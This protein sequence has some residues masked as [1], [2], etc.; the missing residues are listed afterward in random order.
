MTSFTEAPGPLTPQA[1]KGKG[2][3]KRSP[4][5]VVSRVMPDWESPGRRGDNLQTTHRISKNFLKV[6]VSPEDPD[7]DIIAVHGLNPTNTEFHAEATWT[8]EDKLWLRDFL[9]PQLPSARV[10]LFGYNANVAFE[11]SKAGV[12]EQAIN[13]L[14]RIASKREEAEERPIVFVA[15]SL[16]GIVVK[17]A[18]VEAKLDDSYKSIREATYG[19]AFFGT[20][21]QGGNFL[22]LGDI[23]ASIIRGVLRNPSSTFME[24]LKKDSLFS[25]TLVG[26]FRHQLEDHHVLSFF[27]TLPMGRLGLIV[28]QKSATLG[29]AGLRERQ[30]PMD[31]D[32][33]GVCKF[34]SAEGDDYEQVSFN[35]VRLVKSA[36]KAAAERAR[37][38]SLSV[39]SSR[40]LSEA[41]SVDTVTKSLLSHL[42]Y[43]VD[44]PFN[45]YSRQHDPTCLPDTRVDL[46]REIYT[47]AD[48][49]D[50]RF[51]YWLNGLAGTGKS[52]IART[53][54]RKY[55]E[56]G[57]L[58]ASFFFLR[59]GGDVGHA[60]KFFITIAVQLARK[61]QSLQRYI[62]DAVRKNA[63]IATQS[64]GDQWRQVVLGP[65]SKLGGD[66]YPSSYILVIDALDECDNDEDIL[67]I[68]KLLAEAQTLRTVRLRV[69]LTSRSEIPIRY[70]FYQ[71]P[72]TEHQDFVLHHI[73]PSI[74]DHDITI[75]LKY[76]LGLIAQKKPSLSASWPG[77]ETVKQ[78]VQ[79]ASGLFIWA[80][81]ACRFIQEVE[82][83]FLIPK[84]LATILQIGSSIVGEQPEKYLNEIYSTV[85][86]HSIPAKGS[87]EE[88]ERFLSMLRDI[89][90]SIV[91]LLS[92][93]S[94]HSLSRLLNFQP[95]EVDDCLEDLHAI[96]DISRDHTRLLRLHH[97]SFRDFLLKK[98]RCNDSNFWVD[99]KPANETLAA[100]CIQ[101]M[102]TSL[103][104]D[105]CGVTIPGT[106]VADIQ[107]SRVEQCLPLEVQYAC[108]HWVKHLRRSDAQLRD[109]D[110]V[111]QFLQKHLL[112]WLEALGWMQKISEG[113]LEIISLESI[114]SVVNC[115]SLYGF[116]HDLKRFAL[117]NRVGIEQAPLQVY[118]SALFF[119][120]VMSIVR[121]QFSNKMPW[122]IK[123][124]PEVE[125]N[126]S[127]TLQTL[128]GHSS[129]VMA[130]AFSPDGKQLASGSGDETVRI[131]DAATGATLQTFEGHSD[132]VGAVAFSPDGKQLASG[133]GDETVRI[134]DAPTG[135]TLQ[136]LEGHSGLVFGVAFSPDG[137]QLASGSGDET[138]R[139]WD[140]ATGATLQTLEGH[141]GRVGAVAF[142]PDG[143]QLASGSDDETVRIW[144]AATGAT[145]QTL[146]GHSD[147]VGAVAFSPDGK[148]LASGSGD[149]TVRIW[150]AGTGATL[151]T[152]EGHSGL[153]FAVAFSPD[154]KQ[155]A[156]GSY[157]MTVRIWDAATGATLQTLE[158]HSGPVFAVAFSPD[159]KQLAS[160]SGD[161]TVRIWDAATGATLQ[162]LE[163]HSGPVFGV[164][165]SPDGKQLAS[166]SGD[167]TVRIRDAATG[168]TLQTF[169]ASTVITRLS[170]SNDGS[171]VTNC[172]RLDAISLHEDAA[173]SSI[174][175][176]LASRPV[177][178]R[179]NIFVE[180]EW[181]LHKESRMLWLPPDY[182]PICSA[183]YEN[184]VI[185]D[186]G[187]SKYKPVES[188]ALPEEV[189]DLDE[190]VFIIRARTNRKTF[191]QV[192]YVDIKSEG[193]RD[194][195]R[196]VLRD[197]R[198]LSLGEDKINL[199]QNLLYHY[200]HELGAHRTELEDDTYRDAKLKHLN[201]LVEYIRTTYDA[202]KERATTTGV[203][204]FQ[205]ECR[206]L[207]FN[208]QVFG[209][210]STALGMGT[211]QGAKQIDSLEAFPL[212]FH[213]R[214]KEMREHC[215]RCEKGDYVEVPVDS[216]IMVDVAYFRKVN[217]NYARPHINELARPSSLH[218]FYNF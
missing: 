99:E 163:G 2:K 122:W 57:Q 189:T 52:T 50:G 113:I 190:Y 132:W 67:T 201:L 55:F 84:R 143:K 1:S 135:A 207:D 121:K 144:D 110:Y 154:G 131:W 72:E 62:G 7:V 184:I 130:V 66:S 127:A 18:L 136:T 139:I 13:L 148:Q 116:I 65:L 78:L 107:R 103:K 82:K 81:T 133:S 54:A 19:I 192:F 90:G 27:E 193:L 152:L 9:P 83:G 159:G 158:G 160:G 182:R 117:H 106:L 200:V 28:D 40:P 138:V 17:R 161:K 37:I 6:L 97:P 194:V 164:A 119:T 91:T 153:V 35:L 36:V 58:G 10:L 176:P 74:V 156:S 173:F 162:T 214:Q 61:S 4:T 134:W 155:L 169:E 14:N 77:E 25:D 187:A 149:M 102:S 42:P 168:A 179:P 96:L 150:D 181:L 109:N 165:F 157:D 38:A 215:V 101:L 20:P 92:P 34:E 180:D 196:I 120:P 142:S 43:A 22:K 80:A 87:E 53:V 95:G 85:L 79:I 111:H 73:S 8:V 146:E 46:L 44:A 93:L 112:H 151:Q 203:T 210:V 86:R 29:L 145:L 98:D 123:R 212:A 56:N 32:H 41:A 188:A 12:R 47:W 205:V 11:T 16:G 126:W 71:I 218:G 125:Q 178:F 33:T 51:I 129:I 213:R 175:S 195:L 177:A 147:R 26:D 94:I 69:L 15:H 31:A 21:H 141:S 197:V 5:A 198:G 172:G 76:N 59:G 217:P 167:K 206:Y 63:D 23:A 89:L 209:E 114:P 202:G 100:R 171:I 199:E 140:A 208:G 64:L 49:K 105:I 185:S 60:S 137:K 70:G 88:K 166:G 183:V 174:S 68:L 30:I 128:E 170:Y 24:A 75:F 108:L 211:F 104:E 39:P 115:L 216:R 48:G 45:T 124:G 186:D 3:R 118:H 204:Y 191:K